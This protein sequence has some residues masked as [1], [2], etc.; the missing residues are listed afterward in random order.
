MT[1]ETHRHC[2]CDF[3]SGEDCGSDNPEK[4]NAEEKALQ[5]QRDAE[6]RKEE[7]E[8]ILDIFDTDIRS[9]GSLNHQIGRRFLLSR[10]ESLRSKP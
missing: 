5:D 1:R 2:Q 4:K 7:R 3:C 9:Y 8:R 6:I 10:I